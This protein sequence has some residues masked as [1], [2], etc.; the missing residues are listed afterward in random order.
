MKAKKSTAYIVITLFLC[1]VTMADNLYARDAVKPEL[2]SEAKIDCTAYNSALLTQKQA[3][4]IGTI[5]I[6][7]DLL[8]KYQDNP[9]VNKAADKIANGP[10]F[11][12]PVIIEPR[13]DP[14]LPPELPGQDGREIDGEEV[15]KGPSGDSGKKGF[16]ETKLDIPVPEGYEI[17][18]YAG[19][20]PI[21]KETTNKPDDSRTIDDV[22]NGLE[23]SLG[24]PLTDDERQRITGIDR[25]ISELSVYILNPGVEYGK[26]GGGFDISFEN[27]SDGHGEV[28]DSLH[29]TADTMEFLRQI[30]WTMVSGDGNS[31]Y[32]FNGVKVNLVNAKDGPIVIIETGDWKITMTHYSPP[33]GISSGD[34][35]VVRMTFDN[36]RRAKDKIADEMNSVETSGTQV[37]TYSSGSGVS[38]TVPT[39]EFTTT[40]NINR[41]R[42]TGSDAVSKRHSV[43]AK[44]VVYARGKSGKR[45][46]VKAGV[47]GI[48][49]DRFALLKNEWQS[50]KTLLDKMIEHIAKE[51]AGAV[52]AN[53][54]D[55]I[56]AII[57]LKVKGATKSGGDE[58]KGNNDK[59]S[60]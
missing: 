15:K 18:G 1:N 56:E 41:A 28:F 4:A 32:E 25:I 13:I 23:E 59:K 2:L 22:M 39:D 30:F 55:T 34:P 20:V 36:L 21:F 57:L 50:R 33:V 29:L 9:L 11:Y 14:A 16:P 40:R 54:G 5:D 19:G 38:G 52:C 7:N 47:G 58:D 49:K 31:S 24:R 8:K 46:I 10:D 17:A 48:T 51:E 6:K 53:S 60:S 3:Q 43:K 12:R 27:L 26:S 42:G 35:A 44:N 37:L 45:N